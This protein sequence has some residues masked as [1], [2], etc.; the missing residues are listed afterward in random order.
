[1][2]SKILDQMSGTHTTQDLD[3]KEYVGGNFF[4]R[5]REVRYDSGFFSSDSDILPNCE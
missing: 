1:M 2:K 4:V 5:E 3:E